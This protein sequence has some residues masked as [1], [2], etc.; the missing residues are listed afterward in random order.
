MKT[1]FLTIAAVLSIVF[2]VSNKSFAAVAN[3]NNVETTVLSDISNINKI[4]IHGNVELYVTSGESDKVK[5]YDSYYNQNAL[6]QEQNGVLRI[7][8]YKAEKLVVWVTAADLRAISAYDN[9]SVKSFGKLSSLEMNISLNNNATASVDMD[10]STT[11]IVLNDN[12][13]ADIT[14]VAAQSNLTVNQGATVNTSKFAA[15][16]STMKRI[17]PVVYAKNELDE[18]SAA[19]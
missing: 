14:G 9:S 16:Q 1:Q 2:S 7:S 13:K 18:L 4:E 12:T 15:E 10:C 19:N 3:N 8:S 5:V 11:N 6:V 17:S